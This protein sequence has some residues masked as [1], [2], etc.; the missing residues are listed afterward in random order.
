MSIE[1]LL[2]SDV[3]LYT[4]N[5]IESFTVC[6][7]PADGRQGG[8][9]HSVHSTPQQQQSPTAT[10]HVPRTSG[11]LM[12]QHVICVTWTGTAMTLWGM[13]HLNDP[14]EAGLTTVLSQT[15]LLLLAKGGRHSGMLYGGIGCWRKNSQWPFQELWED[16]VQLMGRKRLKMRGYQSH[17]L[18][19]SW[20]LHC[21]Q[22]LG[23]IGNVKDTWALMRDSFLNRVLPYTGTAL[24]LWAQ[25]AAE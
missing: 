23:D 24:L 6:F 25:G 1:A 20:T 16:C 11:P 14:P 21:V 2:I 7:P 22:L 13:L 10:Y 18:L 19:V 8:S 9:K 12:W 5:W 3:G 17:V 15:K 4:Q